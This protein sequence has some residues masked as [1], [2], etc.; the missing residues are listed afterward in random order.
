MPFNQILLGSLLLL[1]GTAAVAQSFVSIPGA[2]SPVSPVLVPGS[3]TSRF[4]F[5]NSTGSSVVEIDARTGSVLS[6][7]PTLARPQALTLQT[8]GSSSHIAVAALGPPGPTSRGGY[9]F[10]NVGVSPPQA[11]QTHDGLT[12]CWS[13][14]GPVGGL[15]GV[16]AFLIST[17]PAN[18]RVHGV[19]RQK[20]SSGVIVSTRA[21]AFTTTREPTTNYRQNPR[22]LETPDAFWHGVLS[23]CAGPL[24]P[25]ALASCFGHITVSPSLVGIIITNVGDTEFRDGEFR[26]AALR[27]NADLEKRALIVS[28]GATAT[29]GAALIGYLG[30][31]PSW[32][33]CLATP[34]QLTAV[35]S[36]CPSGGTVDPGTIA[37]H[38]DSGRVYILDRRVAALHAITVGPS[39]VST[40]LG[41]RLPSIGRSIAIDQSR[42]RIV[43]GT[44]F[45]FVTVDGHAINPDGSAPVTIHAAGFRVDSLGIDPAS[46]NVLALGTTANRAALL[47][48]DVAP[49]AQPSPIATVALARTRIAP[50]QPSALTIDL[51]S[52]ARNAS[53]S[54]TFQIT[55]PSLLRWT[56]A[57]PVVEV[58]GGC[59]AANVQVSNKVLTIG[60]LSVPAVTQ[61]RVTIG[62]VTGTLPG[63]CNQNATNRTVSASSISAPSF[64]VQAQDS[65]VI[66]M[67]S[68]FGDI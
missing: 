5:A 58:S 30:F 48:Y 20:S 31:S 2:I 35:K 27:Q 40:T 28:V 44:D 45:G 47:R 17:N 54:G 52:T 49:G 63:P 29:H 62:G 33:V 25:D 66:V 51:D 16:E 59:S 56:S 21:H 8:V 57:T 1:I 23:R 4:F 22:S 3:G 18:Q 38:N 19:E 42:N 64:S 67:P 24:A 41:I 50:N 9:Q 26:A 37:I 43:V 6:T 55:L 36:P 32:R 7:T 13:A 10:W 53:A 12:P 46:G 15:C 61:C 34:S 14:A 11:A 65:C 39:G 60:E 68:G